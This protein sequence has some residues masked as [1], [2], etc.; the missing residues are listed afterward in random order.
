MLEGAEAARRGEDCQVEMLEVRGL[1]QD[2]KP[3]L[4]WAGEKQQREDD[5]SIMVNKGA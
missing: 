5:E 2:H 3:R 1:R 4:D